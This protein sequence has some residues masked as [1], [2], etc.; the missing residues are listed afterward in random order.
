MSIDESNL[1]FQPAN[2]KRIREPLKIHLKELRVVLVRNP[3]CEELT[4]RLLENSV[5]NNVAT[6]KKGTVSKKRGTINWFD[7]MLI[8]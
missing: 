8:Q 5:P 7:L 2:N 6:A 3:K 1:T 4:A